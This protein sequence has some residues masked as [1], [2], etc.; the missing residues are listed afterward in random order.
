MVAVKY[1]A[2]QCANARLVSSRQLNA[3]MKRVL[4]HIDETFINFEFRIHR[5]QCGEDTA[6]VI[7]HTR[8]LCNL[9]TAPPPPQLPPVLSPTTT[10]TIKVSVSKIIYFEML[11]ITVDLPL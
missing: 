10:S 4:F 1:S 2:I 9:Q 3:Y 6:N 5:K 8:R 7:H 11:A